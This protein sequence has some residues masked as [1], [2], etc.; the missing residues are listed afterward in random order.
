MQKKCLF[1]IFKTYFIYFT[2]S[3]YNSLNIQILFLHTTH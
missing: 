2:I 3:F 1:Y